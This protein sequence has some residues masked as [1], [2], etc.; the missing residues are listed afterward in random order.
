MNEPRITIARPVDN[1]RYCIEIAGLGSTTLA[2]FIFA[3]MDSEKWIF[4]PLGIFQLVGLLVI[5]F[6]R[7]SPSVI[8]ERNSISWFGYGLL[9]PTSNLVSFIEISSV[10]LLDDG[11]RSKVLLHNRYSGPWTIGDNCFIDGQ[12]VVSAIRQFRPDMPISTTTDN[13]VVHRSGP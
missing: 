12:A 4:Y 8:V 13:H 5:L 2:F 3:A 1:R 10:E 7:P 9:G 6:R 11:S